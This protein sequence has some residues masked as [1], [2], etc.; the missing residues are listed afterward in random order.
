MNRIDANS[1]SEVE[2]LQ[3][4]PLCDQ[5]GSK[6]M[7]IPTIRI[8][9]E[10][11]KKHRPPLALVRCRTC[12]LLYVNPRP[13][14]DSLLGFYESPGYV[15]HALGYGK[16]YDYGRVDFMSRFAK[17]LKL[18]DVG[19]GGGTFLTVARNRGYLVTGMEPSSQGRLSATQAGLEVFENV[20]DLVS[21]QRKFDVITIWHVLEHVP[22][23]HV[24]LHD[25]R[26]LLAPG[27]VVIIAVPN[28]FSARACLLRTF[29]ALH[30]PGDVAYRAFPIHLYAFCRQNLALLLNNCGFSVLFSTT[31]YFALDECLWRRKAIKPNLEANPG[32]A[33]ALPTTV[34]TKRASGWRKLIQPLK[35][36]F[37]GAH[38]G[39]SLIMV[40]KN[41]HR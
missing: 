21:K 31:Q 5:R 2:V 23:I 33:G 15:H 41:G 30:P 7:V 37:F 35:R 8:G 28:A 19:C 38:L 36:L 17:G 27:G 9:E 13:T 29:P 34:E 18:L 11:F 40:A 22:D 4:C 14:P 3:A 6:T 20:A 25:I 32:N 12:G 10:H 16:A 39:E 24:F 1:P 26:N